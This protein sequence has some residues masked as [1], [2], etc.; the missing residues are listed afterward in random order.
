MS[1]K[2]YKQI[3]KSTGVIGGSQVI[4]VVI[5]IIKTKFIA[6]LLGPAGF[7]LVG[8]YQ[9]IVDLVRSVTSFGIDFSAVRD[10]AESSGDDEGGGKVTRTY[11]VVYRLT[12]WTGLLGMLIT[13]VFS[14]LFSQYT[15]GDNTHT[16][17]ICLI[18]VTLV[19]DSISGGKSALIQGMMQ[20]NKLAKVKILLSIFSLFISIPL[21]YFYNISAVVPVIIINSLLSLVLFS[22][23]SEKLDYKSFRI[24]IREVFTEGLGMIRLG[25]YTSFVTFLGMV[26]MYLV[27]VFVIK[28][29]GIGSVGCFQAAWSFSVTY[30]GAVL[31]AMAADFF[32]RL[33]SVNKN[34]E[35]VREMVN[36]QT[37]MALF[38]AGPIIISMLT[39]MPFLI[40]LFYSQEFTPAIHILQWQILGDFMKILSWPIGM[41]LLAKN[42][43]R[44][45]VFVEILWLL[46]FMGGVYV[47]WDF[48]GLDVTGISFLASYGIYYLVVFAVVS[49][50]AGFR[51]T[52]KTILFALVYGLIAFFSFLN[53]LLLTGLVRYLIGAVLVVLSCSFSFYY[54]NK[55]TDVFLYMKR[56]LGIL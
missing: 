42:I 17:L 44:F 25:F 30:I 45:F 3:L 14:P 29:G 10:I 34:T 40:N 23:F 20:I 12:M 46:L 22:H 28:K 54:L 9:S 52:S 32:P 19:I 16:F 8:L 35:K 43:S 51:Y 38:L 1:N 48:F 49:R 24:K 2:G 41:I 56:K 31:T 11:A 21:Y 37:Q 36:E 13:A 27:K 39:F 15:F 47:G 6:V 33:S 55:Y 50:I 5:G 26:A 53:G 18:S 4:T 7:G